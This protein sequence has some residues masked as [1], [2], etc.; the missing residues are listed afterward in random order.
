MFYEEDAKRFLGAVFFRRRARAGRIAPVK[1][2][3]DEDCEDLFLHFIVYCVRAR[4][5]EE[6]AGNLNAIANDIKQT[7]HR[8]D[9]AKQIGE[10]LKTPKN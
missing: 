9:V 10:F 8:D 5:S 6:L 1:L 4:G 3:K 2:V 7:I